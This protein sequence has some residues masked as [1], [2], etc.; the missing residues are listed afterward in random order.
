MRYARQL[1]GLASLLVLLPLTSGCVTYGEAEARQAARQREDILLLQEDIR[2]LEGRLEGLEMQQESLRGELALLHDNQSRQV[3]EQTQSLRRT[4]QSLEKRMSGLEAARDKDKQEII[5]RLSE[6]IGQLMKKSGPARTRPATS[7]YGYEH[8]VQPGET[9][10]EIAGAYGVTT[11]VIIEANQIENP[12]HL[13]V[14][15]TL[16]IPD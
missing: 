12:D 11:R 10:S 7:G 16:F 3:E 4:V 8:V 2:R 13:R 6:R 14:G 5:D 9:L 1:Y 15:Q